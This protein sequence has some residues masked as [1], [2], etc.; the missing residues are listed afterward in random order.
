V[1][2]VQLPQRP[3][4]VERARDDPRHLLGELFVTARGGQGELAHVEV[5]VEVD[6]V[7]PVG[8]V[9][10]ERHLGRTPAQG[11]Q[12]RQPLGQKQLDVLDRQLAP[13]RGRRVEDGQA[14]HMAV[15]ARVL[16]RQELRVEAG[17]LS[18]PNFKYP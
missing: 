9:E 4:A 3:R 1:D 16:Q 13:R 7:D 14:G 6:V 5:E 8:I 2:E 17:E 18:H 15:L 11:R 10:P 12:Q